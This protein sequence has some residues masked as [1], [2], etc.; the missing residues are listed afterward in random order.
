MFGIFP[1]SKP[2]KSYF[3]E[4]VLPV[5]IVLCLLFPITNAFC[6]QHPLISGKEIDL[7]QKETKEYSFYI[8]CLEDKLSASEQRLASLFNATKALVQSEEWLAANVDYQDENSSVV[9]DNEKKLVEDRQNWVKHR[10]LFCDLAT[11]QISENAQNH[12]PLLT[13]CKINLNN[14]RIKELEVLRAQ[15]Q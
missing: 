10:D 13:Q 3:V 7:C 14:G 4:M 8:R 5:S 12:Y 9:S 1:V 15:R 6:S 11:S 2:D